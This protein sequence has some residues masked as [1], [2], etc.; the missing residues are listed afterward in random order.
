MFR[1]YIAGPRRSCFLSIHIYEGTSGKP[2]S[3]AM[4]Q[5]AADVLCVE[6]AA[7]AAAKL[8]S[9]ATLSYGVKG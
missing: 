6:R 5:E 2:L 1:V 7:R 9:F 3:V 4:T 8:R